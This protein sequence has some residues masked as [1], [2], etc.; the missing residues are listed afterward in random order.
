MSI[1]TLAIKDG[2]GANRVITAIDVAGDGSGP[3]LPVHGLANSVG[4]AIDPATSAKQDSLIALLPTSIG[5]KTTAASLSVTLSSNHSVIAVSATA[6]PLPSGAATSA[7]QDSLFALFPTSIGQKAAAGSLSVV[8]AS[9]QGIIGVSASSLPLPT[10]AATAAKQDTLLAAVQAGIPVTAT[11]SADQD[12]IFDHTNG[13][14]TSVTASATVITPPTG[15]RFVRIHTD[16]D[17]FVNTAGNAAV[18]DGTSIRIVANSSE[19]IP[20]VAGVAVR[21]LSSSGTAI[22]RCTPLKV[23]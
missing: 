23:R 18:D 20:V 10:G 8:I 2:L 4:T 6:L 13:T 7:K 16:V 19:V 9:D 15:C 21:A 5:Q 17:V 14:K 12:P 11:P 1:T 3:F 22:V